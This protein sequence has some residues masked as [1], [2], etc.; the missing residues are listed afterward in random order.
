[1]N[2]RARYPEDYTRLP[3]IFRHEG[4]RGQRINLVISSARDLH[5]SESRIAC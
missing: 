4:T 2:D 5:I 1:M 3:N